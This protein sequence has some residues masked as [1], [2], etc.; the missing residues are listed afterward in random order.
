MT[1]KHNETII[2]S[3]T[4]NQNY[5]PIKG[6]EFKYTHSSLEMLIDSVKWEDSGSYQLTVQLNVS[7]TMLEALSDVTSL[8]LYEGM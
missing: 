5:Q 8:K 4:N 6:V 3:I 2:F 1:V 7:F